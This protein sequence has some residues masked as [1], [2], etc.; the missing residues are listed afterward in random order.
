MVRGAGDQGGRWNERG[1]RMSAEDRRLWLAVRR[2][3]KLIC[4]A[5]GSDAPPL[6]GVVRQGLTLI[7]GAIE[8]ECRA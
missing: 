2:G 1:D 8:R 4:D 6:W 3:L 7:C 5:I